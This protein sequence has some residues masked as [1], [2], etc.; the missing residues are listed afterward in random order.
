VSF[1]AMIF[2]QIINPESI[3]QNRNSKI[4][5]DSKKQKVLSSKCSSSTSYH[6]S[7]HVGR[8]D[9]GGGGGW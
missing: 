2:F 9:F 3:E 1:L 6:S 5:K 4:S 8:S 7:N